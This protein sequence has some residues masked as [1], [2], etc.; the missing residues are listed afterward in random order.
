MESINLFGVDVKLKTHFC[1]LLG[2][3]HR[4]VEEPYI[5]LYIR[6]KYCNARC[7]F[8]TYHSDASKWN[9]KRYIEVLKELSS[10]I[11]IGKL[12]FSGGEVNIVTGKTLN[13]WFKS[14]KI[15]HHIQSSHLTLM[16]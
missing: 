7:P 3:E 5:N 6:T 13:R 2:Q 16:V 1:S 11:R 15:L 8:C 4:K 14:E 12:A 9:E 10:K